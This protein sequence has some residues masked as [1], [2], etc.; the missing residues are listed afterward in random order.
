MHRVTRSHSASGRFTPFPTPTQSA[1]GAAAAGAATTD[2]RDYHG[3]E[4]D[5]EAQLR[6]GK[7]HPCWTREQQK[8]PT[9]E[10]WIKLEPKLG[11]FG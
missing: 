4:Y 10:Q 9:L 8:D 2:S 11:K 3:G 1:D 6:A 5:V 7:H